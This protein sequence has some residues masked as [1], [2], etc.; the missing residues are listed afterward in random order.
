MDLTQHISPDQILVRD[1]AT[2][3]WE[4]MGR[5]LDRILLSPSFQ[6]HTHMSREAI[7]KELEDREKQQ[8]TGIGHG[9]A[10][11]HARLSEL[12]GLG[13]AL[14]IPAN[15]LPF[16]AADG[17]PVRVICMVLTPRSDPTLALKIYSKIASLLAEPATADFLK[18]AQ[19]PHEV[20][21]FLCERGLN[22]EVVLTA[23]DIMRPAFFKVYRDT[24]LP[25]LTRLMMEHREEATAVLEADDTVAGEITCDILFQYGLPDFFNQLKS[26][27]FISRFDPFEKYFENE[28]HAVAGSI[29]APAPPILPETATLLEVVFALTVQKHPKLYVTRDGKLRGV[30]DRSAVLDRVVNF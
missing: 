1:P 26:V 7:W 25:D 16:G 10:L 27:S 15:D 21:S 17:R 24:R 9:L 2:D 6:H 3:K 4:L 19:T 8:S 13:L 5:L 11:P 23:K 22:L 12:K 30:I 28:S 14:A 29:M 18:A 20:Y